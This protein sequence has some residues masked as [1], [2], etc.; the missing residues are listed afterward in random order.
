MPDHQNNSTLPSSTDVLIV[1]AGPTGLALACA[2]HSQG[3]DYV[4][5][6]RAAS[7]AVHSRAAAVH[8]RTLESLAT[9]GAAD[10]LIERGR[11]GRSFTAR[12]GERSVIHTP[13]DEL[14][15]PYPFV[16]AVPQ[17]TTEE[18]LEERLV[19]LG[20][21]V[22]RRT[23]VFALNELFPGMNALVSS[24]ETGEVRALRA[25][26]VVGCD[27]VHSTV[28]EQSGIPFTGHEKPHNFALIEFTMDWSGPEGE[29]T[30]FFSPSGLLAVSRLEGDTYRA[31]ALVDDDTPAPDERA[32][33]ALLE[34]RGP[35]AAGAKVRELR[36]SSTWRVRHRLADTFGE[37]PVF[38]VGDAA[39]VHSPVGAQGMN[40]GLQ[41]AFNLAWKLA[42]VARGEASP[43][44]LRTYNAERRPMAQ[45]LLAFAAQLHDISTMSD[46]DKIRMR[47]DVLGAAG[48]LP[49]VRA[50]LASRLAQLSVTYGG[51]E[52]P[53]PAVGDRMPPRPGMAPGLGWSLLVPS[54]AGLAA[55]E[56]TAR[57]IPVPVAVAE[58]A[59]LPHAVLVR[60][61][62]HVALTAPVALLAELPG[63]LR[64][65]LHRD[66][67]TGV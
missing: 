30:F 32:V 47:N 63:R 25:R 5:V 4:L 27:G 38:L 49:E 53:S 19:Q 52:G 43:T 11:P 28:R 55:A 67:P 22:H 39:H 31:V 14:D 26:W 23:T 60:P 42:A 20:G 1:G 65:W 13:F 51:G 16:L 21:R 35:S 18:V 40:T 36:M 44:L 7:N 62:G 2:L 50:W 12:D 8:A 64:E 48:Q 61:D 6:D 33:Q 46:P 58:A 17:Q 66:R 57:E 34:S 3:V 9:I 37:G 15:T 10:A 29:I 56:A 54:G 59:G 24:E 45:G 41:D